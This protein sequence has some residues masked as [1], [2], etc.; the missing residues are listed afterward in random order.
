MEM[1]V[2]IGTLLASWPDML[3][4]NFM[5][6][7]LLICQHADD[8]AYGLILNRRTEFTTMN[9]LPDHQVLGKLPFAVHMGGP[10]APTNMQVLHTVPE[11]IPGGVPL[12]ERLWLGG[13]LDA[14][15][16]FIANR[17]EDVSSKVCFFVGYAGW[18]AGQL[19]EELATGSWLPSPLAPEGVLGAGGD[20][21]WRRVV[22]SIGTDGGDLENLPPDVRWN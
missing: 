15:G 6:S 5:H 10:V 19:D 3:D 4:P 8:G 22:R 12:T 7:V 11:A 18:G 1:R 21:V 14:V 9:L 13:E 20:D 16:D 17:N 2:E